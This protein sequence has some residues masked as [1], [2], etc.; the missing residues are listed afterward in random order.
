MLAAPSILSGCNRP[1][2]NA[3][4]LTEIRGEA[5]TLMKTNALD[6]K[7]RWEEVPKDKWPTAISSLHPEAVTVH[8]W[9]VDIRT[10]AYFDGGYGYQVPRSKADLPM[11]AACYSE[12][13]PGLF[14]HGPC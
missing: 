7:K 1:I 14:W 13:I 6:Q 3:E 9:G 5:Q 12:P 4:Q 10:K 11:P 8:V 2:S